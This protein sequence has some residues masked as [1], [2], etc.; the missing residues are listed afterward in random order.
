MSKRIPIP[1]FDDN[2]IN[3]YCP[4]GDIYKGI[5]TPSFKNLQHYD[6]WIT[7]DFSV[8]KEGQT[9]H[10]VGITHPRPK[11]FINEFE[12]DMSD[13]HEAEYQLFHCCACGERFQDVFF[14]KSFKDCEKILYP[15]ERPDEK[16]E[17]WA[18]HLMKYQ[19]CFHIIYSPQEMRRMTSK[20][21]LVWEKAPILFK[22]KDAEARDPYI[23]E[24]NGSFYCLYTENGYLKYRVSVNMKDW[25]EEN[26]LQAPFFANCQTESPFLLK[27]EGI[28]YLF[29]CIYDSRNSCYDN[30]TM[31]FAAETIE[32]LFDS[33]P[34]TMLKAHAPEIVVDRDGSCYLL[35][36]YYPQNGISAVKLKW[37]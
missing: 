6:E 32:G 26:I 30:R 25:S 33:A 13:V 34:I 15:Q 11:G 9:W 18:P 3:V 28:Y 2:Y 27:R 20:D 29:W 14:E 12:F 31:V 4:S 16:P 1:E 17:V 10:I 24:E 21:F 5:D 36:V 19:D 8:L 35:S 22:C 23:F 7:N 37:V